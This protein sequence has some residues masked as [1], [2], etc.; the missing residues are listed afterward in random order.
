MLDGPRPSLAAVGSD[1]ALGRS[2][3]V[4]RQRELAVLKDALAAATEGRA[5][6]VGIVGEAGVGKSRLCEEFA[7]FITARGIT[8]R[9]TTGV[10]HGREVP[11]L[12]ILG[13]LRDYFLITDDDDP[14]QSREKIARRLFELDPALEETLPLLT[15][16]WIFQT[17]VGPPLSWRQRY[18]CGGSS[19]RY[20]G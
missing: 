10:S 18:A 17:S 15:T 3:L 12:P 9:S 19:R 14:D 5:Q 13:L 8:V 2:P 7:R 11:L 4:G 20:T 16:S 1:R 6:I